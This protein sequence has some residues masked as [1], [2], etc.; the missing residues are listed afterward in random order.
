[1]PTLMPRAHHHRSA[2]D[3]RA[4]PPVVDQLSTSLQPP[5]KERIRRTPHTQARRRCLIQNALGFFEADAEGLFA[6]HMLARVQSLQIH[7]PVSLGIRQVQHHINVFAAEQLPDR[8]GSDAKRLS[9]LAGSFIIEIR[10]G[11]DAH[12]IK[13]LGVLEIRTTDVAAADDADA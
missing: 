13:G 6:V 11:D 3:R 7:R 2:R 4:D 5:A 1:M 9:L 12:G 8:H 10:T